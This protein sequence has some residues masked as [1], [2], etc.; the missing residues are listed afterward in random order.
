MKLSIAL[1]LL[2]CSYFFNEVEAARPQNPGNQ[3]NGNGNQVTDNQGNTACGNNKSYLCHHDEGGNAYK[4]LCISDNAINAQLRSD[5]RNYLGQ[6]I[7]DLFLERAVFMDLE[8]MEGVEE[9][10]GD[11]GVSYQVTYNVT[12]LEEGIVSLGAAAD[13]ITSVT[14][15]ND[16]INVEFKQIPSP[17]QIEFMFP[18]F[19]LVVFDGNTFPDMEC[20][21]P[22][23]DEDPDLNSS[24]FLIAGVE[25]AEDKTVT[26][27]GLPANFHHMFE[28][29][30]L[31]FTPVEARRNLRNL[32]LGEFDIDKSFDGS[33][34]V[35]EGED[36]KIQLSAYAKASIEASSGGLHFKTGLKKQKCERRGWLRRLL[37]LV[38][39]KLEVDSSYNLAFDLSAYLKASFV[40]KEDSLEPLNGDMR[41]PFLSFLIFGFK[42]PATLQ[43]TIQKIIPGLKRGYLGIRADIPA[44]LKYD[45]SVT[46]DVEFNAEASI[47]TGK[48][49]LDWKLSGPIF[50]D[51]ESTFNVNEVEPSKSSGI[52]FARNID[53]DVGVKMEGFLFGG[54]ELQILVD[55]IGLWTAGVGMVTG[56]DVEADFSTDPMQPIIS[57]SGPSPIF[58]S[59]CRLCHYGKMTVE[60]AAKQA[61]FRWKLL[62][63]EEETKLLFGDWNVNQLVA[64][65]CLLSAKENTCG[66]ICCNENEVC[67]LDPVTKEGM[68]SCNTE[69]V[70]AQCCR[71]EDCDDSATQFCDGDQQCVL[72][73]CNTEAAETECC[74]DLDCDD[75]GTHICEDQQC[76][77]RACDLANSNTECCTNSDCESG[78]ELCV[79]NFCIK[80]GNPGFSLSWCERD[81]LDLIVIT[82]DGFKI[83]YQHPKD[84]STGGTLDKDDIP[85][86]NEEGRCYV[87]NIVFPAGA[88]KGD[89]VFSVDSYYEHLG[90]DT[91]T[92]RVYLGDE[93]QVVKS[94][95]GDSEEFVY[96]L[97]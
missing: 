20:K 26:I 38:D 32:R 41:S 11:D 7:G 47:A 15:F 52:K 28:E 82:P 56:F 67:I 3:G 97:V 88:P 48:K 9:I 68:C 69:A 64:Q 10:D 35:P 60:A 61:F 5:E 73:D 65:L 81:D 87:E 22:N 93:E 8:P 94:G 92:V 72:R 21:L 71:D 66:D 76:V 27:R 4:T 54:V 55:I 6:C 42:V 80:Q 89:Y 24:F 90:P 63:R 14:C 53:S 17:D 75:S 31:L 85:D 33:F 36:E 1:S 58:E 46:G 49:E 45:L 25:A 37:C 70:G 96:T 2:G 57:E 62:G 77:L 30:E 51:L 16:T 74:R 40:A 59:D 84:P 43:S 91:W 34:Q 29:Q 23:Q 86:V 79:S 44:L 50:G 12:M 18:D 78:T 83:N 19:A 13:L 39:Y 95:T